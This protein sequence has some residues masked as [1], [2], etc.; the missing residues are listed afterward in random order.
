MF[1]RIR[2]FVIGVVSSLGAIAYLAALVKRARERLTTQAL[3]RSSRH[4]VASLLDRAADRI[5]PDAGVG[6]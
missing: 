6:P 1:L 3:A 5:A 4:G 2:W